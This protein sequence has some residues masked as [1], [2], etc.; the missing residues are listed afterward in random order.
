MTFQERIRE[1]QSSFVMEFQD[2]ETC[3][4]LFE[5]L[6]HEYSMLPKEEQLDRTITN[7]NFLNLLK[8]AKDHRGGHNVPPDHNDPK[9]KMDMEESLTDLA[10]LIEQKNPHYR[11][12][13]SVKQNCPM[14]QKPVSALFN[15]VQSL[16]QQ[17]VPVDPPRCQACMTKWIEERAM[18]FSGMSANAQP[19][20][21]QASPMSGEEISWFA[22]LEKQMKPQ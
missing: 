4:A 10:R 2:R 18:F 3:I 15:R 7:E 9:L 5:D 17:M 6:L 20:D 16:N 8:M 13:D 19:V 22:S 1:I 14:C 12:A 21:S 11:I